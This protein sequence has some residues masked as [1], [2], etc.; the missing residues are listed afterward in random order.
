ME[1][2]IDLIVKYYEFFGFFIELRRFLLTKG[3]NLKIVIDYKLIRS[4]FLG[5]FCKG[6][7]LN[8]NNCGCCESHL[9]LFDD[10]C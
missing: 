3:R 4:F 7:V 5:W 9:N 10:I 6:E 8:E 2:V 1:F